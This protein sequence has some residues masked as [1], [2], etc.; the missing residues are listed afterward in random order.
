M[1]LKEKDMYAM[2]EFSFAD[3]SSLT[4]AR[5]AALDAATGNDIDTDVVGAEE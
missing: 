4:A 1:N 3:A 2:R 5:Q